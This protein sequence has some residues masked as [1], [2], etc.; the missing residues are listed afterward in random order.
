MVSFLPED[1]RGE[2]LARAMESRGLGGTASN[3]LLLS[4][5]IDPLLRK[6]RPTGDRGDRIGADGAGNIAD[7]VWIVGS[8]RRQ[9]I[10]ERRST[11]R[12]ETRA[13]VEA[14]VSAAEAAAQMSS[15]AGGL[16]DLSGAAA[17]QDVPDVPD[18]GEIAQLRAQVQARMGEV[19][20]TVTE[21]QRAAD[22]WHQRHEVAAKRGDDDE[23]R[24]AERNADGERARMHAALAEMAQLQGE[25]SRL[26]RAA[27][28]AATAPR[29]PPG[30]RASSASSS[31][32]SASASSSAGAGRPSVDDLLE[33]MKRQG[34]GTSRRSPRKGENPKSPPT[35][36]TRTIDD[37]LAALKRKMK[38][39]KE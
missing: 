24:Q 27:E 25:L 10:E 37:E 39:K 8:E 17:P 20:K 26:D 21:A 28:V 13:R 7:V 18:I 38:R 6:P 14:A 19:G 32:A 15:A 4:A 11:A 35:P 2:H 3:A 16:E 1:K 22:S 12:A 34:G 29:P 5:S 33:Q 23:A 36:Q 30:A 9:V 31:A